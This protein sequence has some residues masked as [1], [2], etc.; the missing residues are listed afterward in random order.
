MET[1]FA[2]TK[3]GGRHKLAEMLGVA[4][5]TTYQ[6]SWNP[7]LPPKHERFLRALRPKWFAEWGAAQAAKES[8]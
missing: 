4:L 6:K 3:A 7:N 2:S 8:T 5:I 1:E